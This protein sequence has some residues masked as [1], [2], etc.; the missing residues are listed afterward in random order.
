M[1]LLLSIMLCI[2]HGFHDSYSLFHPEFKKCFIYFCILFWAIRC[3][4]WDLRIAS[5]GWLSFCHF[6]LRVTVRSE[7]MRSEPYAIGMRSHDNSCSVWV[8]VSRF[9]SIAR[10]ENLTTTRFTPML[11]N[12]HTILLEFF[13][14]LEILVHQISFSSKCHR[15]VTKGNLSLLRQIQIITRRMNLMMETLMA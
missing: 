8:C 3:A 4:V 15:V 7:P 2:N 12:K 1:K 10:H 9:L 5:L 14:K 6:C 13:M 11:L